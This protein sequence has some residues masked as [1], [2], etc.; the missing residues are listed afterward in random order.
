MFS[1]FTGS[2]SFKRGQVTSASPPVSG[3]AVLSLDADGYSGSGNWLDDTQNWIYKTSV[4][5][6]NRNKN[7][8]RKSLL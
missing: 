5:T 7:G 3:T 1:S 4:S 2:F 6:M 8:I